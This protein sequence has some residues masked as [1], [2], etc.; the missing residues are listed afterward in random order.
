M[1]PE[2]VFTS[3]FALVFPMHFTETGLIYA[4]Y[5][6]VVFTIR[7]WKFTNSHIFLIFAT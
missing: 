5:V 2:V 3:S 4:E 1:C 7:H 6:T